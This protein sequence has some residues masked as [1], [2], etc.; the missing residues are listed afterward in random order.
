MLWAIVLF[1]R[2]WDNSHYHSQQSQ[3]K[4]YILLFDKTI[5]WL[6]VSCWTIEL[7]WLLFYSSEMGLFFLFL[8]LN[9]SYIFSWNGA[10]DAKWHCFLNIKKN[11]Y[12]EHVRQ[13]NVLNIS[14]IASWAKEK[15]TS[16]DQSWMLNVERASFFVFFCKKN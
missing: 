10:Y 9:S 16:T 13:I 7:Y 11:I 14:W 6:C 2:Y 3:A 15:S 5:V 1:K 12:L 8:C 4:L